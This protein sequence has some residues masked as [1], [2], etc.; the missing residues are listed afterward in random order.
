[1]TK[2][3]IGKNNERIKKEIADK[4]KRIKELEES[5]RYYQKKHEIVEDLY[6]KA[7]EIVDSQKRLEEIY[8]NKKSNDNKNN[9][10]ENNDDEDD[11]VDEL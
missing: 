8:G 4:D 1:M 6:E 3:N 2:Y 7:Q 11:D 9:N 10:N 5:L